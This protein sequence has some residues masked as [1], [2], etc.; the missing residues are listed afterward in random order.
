[1]GKIKRI[2]MTLFTAKNLE[3]GQEIYHE[4][5]KNADGTPMRA[6]VTSVKTWKRTLQNVEVRYKRG[7]AEYGSFNQ[8]ELKNYTAIDRRE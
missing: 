5:A 8:G 4:S 7:M 3:K 2:G 6:K 1:M